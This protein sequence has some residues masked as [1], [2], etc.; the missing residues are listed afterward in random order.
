[1]IRQGHEPSENDAKDFAER[2]RMKPLVH[3]SPLTSLEVDMITSFARH[4]E[5][6]AT[7]AEGLAFQEPVSKPDISHWAHAMA[8]AGE[9]PEIEVSGGNGMWRHQGEII[10]GNM[11]TF[12][13]S[14]H[15]KTIQKTEG[16]IL[17]IARPR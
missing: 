13:R 10:P 2:L 1:M 15:Q 3:A 6:P 14:L 12:L 5:T 8:L 4:F 17:T 9:Q 7:D 16:L 11:G